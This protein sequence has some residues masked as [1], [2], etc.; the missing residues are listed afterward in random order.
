MTQSVDEIDETGKVLTD[1]YPQDEHDAVV[2]QLRRKGW[3]RLDA[4]QEADGLM[5]LRIAR[6]KCAERDAS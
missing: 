4:E 6:R 1:A 5:A 3:D 2:E